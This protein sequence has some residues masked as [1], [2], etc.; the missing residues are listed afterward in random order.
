MTLFSLQFTEGRGGCQII[1]DFKCQSEFG[2]SVGSGTNTCAEDWG[3][4]GSYTDSLINCC[5]GE[6]TVDVKCLV[7]YGMQYWHFRQRQNIQRHYAKHCLAG[8]SNV[9]FFF[10]NH[11][12]SLVVSSNVAEKSCV[13]KIFFLCSLDFQNSNLI[14][15]RFKQRVCSLS[16]WLTTGVM[17]VYFESSAVELRRL[18]ITTHH[19]YAAAVIQMEAFSSAVTLLQLKESKNPAELGS[20][21]QG[22]QLIVVQ[23]LVD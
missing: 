4:Y 10:Q 20:Q 11:A 13:C 15:R 16:P 17:E 3:G 21:A 1:K 9:S 18:S 19:Y 8:N 22:Q 12:L 14:S 5:E 2:I 7:R 23:A 6:N